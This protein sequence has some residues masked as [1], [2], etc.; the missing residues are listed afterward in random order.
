MPSHRRH[1]CFAPTTV[2]LPPARAPPPGRVWLPA[3]TAAP[4]HPP[5]PPWRQRPQEEAEA[6]STR[7]RRQSPPPAPPPPSLRRPPA[8]STTTPR[9]WP[10]ASQEAHRC[11]RCSRH[12]AASL[13]CA[14]TERPSPRWCTYT[15]DP[16]WAGHDRNE[17]S[18]ASM[19]LARG[20]A[21]TR[22]EAQRAGVR[23]EERRESSGST[24]SLLLS[25]EFSELRSEGSALVGRGVLRSLAV[26]SCDSPLLCC[27][28][29]L[30]ASLLV[31]LRAAVDSS[32]AL[33]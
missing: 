24:H 32:S 12:H 8:R 4:E 23:I 33:W 11:R 1:Q 16:R 9:P 5:P 28:R 6:T 20:G 25:E 19:A 17:P 30:R 21:C 2:S 26:S 29:L 13:G 14:R 31:V 10:W 3:A 7:R 27:E 18:V 22:A 15:R